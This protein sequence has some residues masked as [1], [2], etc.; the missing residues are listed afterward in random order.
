MWS[1]S[2]LLGLKIFQASL[3]E[4]LVG[5]GRQPPPLPRRRG[6]RLAATHGT[7]GEQGKKGIAMC[8]VLVMQTDSWHFVGR[9]FPALSSQENRKALGKGQQ[10]K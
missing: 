10:P 8:I 7:R 9:T 5:D 4:L 6:V 1:S 3:A 2:K